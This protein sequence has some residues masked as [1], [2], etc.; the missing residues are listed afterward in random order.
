LRGTVW[1]FDFENGAPPKPALVVSNN[2]RNAS[3]WPMVHVVR[4]TTAPKTPRATI[5]E[6]PHGESVSGRVLCDELQ[7]VP[8]SQLRKRVGALSPRTMRAID[9]G[10]RA[11]LAL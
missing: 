10:L 2:S 4:I 7:Q 11:V 1:E 8:K 5:V 6:I 3:T 9:D